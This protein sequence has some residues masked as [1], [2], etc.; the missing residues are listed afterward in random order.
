M[1]TIRVYQTLFEYD[2][3]QVFEARDRIGG[4]YVGVMAPEGHMDWRSE[5]LVAGVEPERLRQFRAGIIDLR[6]LLLESAPDLRY[7]GALPTRFE[8]EFEIRPLDAGAIDNG[9]LPQPGFRLHEAPA[10]DAVVQQAQASNNLVLRVSVE[11]PEAATEHRIHATTL[12]EL[13][14][15][16]Q[17]LVRRAHGFVTKGQDASMRR[18]GE[19]R[20]DVIVPAAAGSFELVLEAQRGDLFGDRLRPAMELV[21]KL[22]GD[23]KEPSN[24]SDAV[25]QYRG[26]LAA[27]YLR[28]LRFLSEHETGL[29]YAWAAPQSERAGGCAISHSEASAVMSR[30]SE[31]EDLGRERVILEG[32]FE[33]FDRQKGQWGLRT[34]S[35]LRRG[36][37]GNSGT[38]LD[39]LQV[40]ARYCFH[41]DEEI[42]QAYVT[43][44]ER[45]VLVLRHHEVAQS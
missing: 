39:G 19:D 24:A 42:E 13:L 35:G 3:P 7:R 22:L 4:H 34:E 45:R 38:S 11:P 40:G 43:G 20:L 8:A 37:I 29:R 36:G 5:F 25:A 17:V 6:T 30:L 26:H 31:V 44:E 21:D 1:K 16:I 9:L 12:A 32:T 41:C 14:H 28:L 10:K 2:G 15:R 18:S 33:R 27:A 23:V